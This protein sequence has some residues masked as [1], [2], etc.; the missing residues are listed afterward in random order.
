[1]TARAPILSAEDELT[2]QLI[3]QAA[4]KKTGLPNPL[5]F[6]QDGQ[7]AVD[8]LAGRPPYADRGAHPLPGL[9][10]LDLKMPRMDG[11]DVLT[12]L[13]GQP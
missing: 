11:F 5:V 2:D 3:L 13:A 8:Y 12:W 9:L 6:L 4:F 10:L 7:E 1:M